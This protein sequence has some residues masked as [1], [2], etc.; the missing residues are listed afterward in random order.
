VSEKQHQLTGEA[1]EIMS[2][3]ID[4]K[5][6]RAIAKHFSVSL[7]SLHDFISKPEHSARVHIAMMIS[8]DTFADLGE[9]V[10]L[11]CP[12]DKFEIMRARELA[13]HYRWK[14]AKRNPRRYSEKMDITTDGEKL[15]SPAIHMLPLSHGVKPEAK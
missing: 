4:G 5:T 10:L 13:Q 11:S 12:A 3:S 1:D 6:F 2:L 15:V 7:S 9:Q 8:A 14:S